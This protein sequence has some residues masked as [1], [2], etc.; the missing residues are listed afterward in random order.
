MRLERPKI[1]FSG[2]WKPQGKSVVSVHVEYS[3]TL[4]NETWHPHIP[5]EFRAQSF[6][7]LEG[8]WN[9]EMHFVDM[10]SF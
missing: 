5:I 3:R 4:S 9:L 10:K 7:G 6:W 8:L 1:I 2:L